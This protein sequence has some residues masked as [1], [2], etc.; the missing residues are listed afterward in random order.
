MLAEVLM[1]EIVVDDVFVFI[2]LFKAFNDYNYWR[3]LFLFICSEQ[4]KYSIMLKAVKVWGGF[5]SIMYHLAEDESGP[6]CHV[7]LI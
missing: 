6:T 3:N 7:Y 4:G 1:E 5:G 2:A